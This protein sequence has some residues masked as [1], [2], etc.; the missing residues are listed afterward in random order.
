MVGWYH[1]LNGHEFEQDLGDGERQ[2]G[3][4]CC[5]PWGCKESDTTKCLNNNNHTKG[6]L[7]SKQETQVP[8]LG[9]KDH[10]PGGGHAN[11]LQYSCLENPMDTGAW[12]ATVHRVAKSWTLLK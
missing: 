6:L 1:G 5:S 7:P 3:L 8:S 4:A 10:L 11:S 2:G 12:W 9:C